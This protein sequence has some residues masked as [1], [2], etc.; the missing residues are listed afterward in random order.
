MIFFS[1]MLGTAW[2]FFSS[3]LYPIPRPESL[4]CGTTIQSTFPAYLLAESIECQPRS[5]QI[6]QKT[7][8]YIW[9]SL[10]YNPYRQCRTSGACGKDRV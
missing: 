9:V 2:F 10:E 3:L 8:P 6:I 7:K 1:Q 4:A 5:E